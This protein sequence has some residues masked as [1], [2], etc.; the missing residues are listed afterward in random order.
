MS[1][2]NMRVLDL[3]SGVNIANHWQLGNGLRFAVGKTVTGDLKGRPEV[4][5]D[6]RVTAAADWSGRRTG[7]VKTLLV[8]LIAALIP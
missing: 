1:A 4:S 3:I 2:L 5:E 8:H 7:V 6:E